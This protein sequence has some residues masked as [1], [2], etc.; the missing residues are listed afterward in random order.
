M[1][2]LCLSC[3]QGAYNDKS[4]FRVRMLWHVS[5]PPIPPLTTGHRNAVSLT[6]EDELRS[7]VQARLR[8]ALA[9]RR[10]CD[11]PNDATSAF[12]LVNS[13]GDGL[14]GVVV[15]VFGTVAVVSSS[16]I[17]AEVHRD[18]IVEAVEALG[19]VDRVEWQQSVSRLQQDGWER[20]AVAEEGGVEEEA[21]EAYAD[22]D[23][24][25]GDASGFFDVEV[26]AEEAEE[27]GDVTIKAAPVEQEDEY[28][29]RELGLEY[30]VNLRT[31]QKTGF[32]CDQ[33]DNRAQ[34]RSLV[35][36]DDDVLDVCCYT[37][38]FALN[39]A[40]GGARSVLGID[41]SAAAVAAA[42]RNAAL[43][44]LSGDQITFEKWD[45]MDFMHD[46]VREGRSFSV[47]ILDPPK[48]APS[49]KSLDRAKSRYRRLN[50]LGMQLLKP[51]GLLVTCT[52]SSAMASASDLFVSLPVLPI[53]PILPIPPIPPVLPILPGPPTDKRVLTNMATTVF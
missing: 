5:D 53:L 29:I 52:C 32:Y 26:E 33:R 39:A 51:G 6:R 50:R 3:F 46:A 11:L 48:L 8:S 37:G 28:V 47:V 21:K 18:A 16:A 35:S 27:A 13:E 31:A 23:S 22:A 42:E 38:G 12:R 34:L 40:A 14:S 19:I 49:R 4:M 10:R 36:A 45:M 20:P 9:K 1:L 2:P 44:N 7:L 30:F 17:W 15:D 24:S 43:N 25:T 41:S